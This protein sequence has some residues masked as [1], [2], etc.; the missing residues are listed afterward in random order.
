MRRNLKLNIQNLEPNAKILL[1]GDTHLGHPTLLKDHLQT[2][3]RDALENDYYVLLMGDLIE[4]GITGSVGDSLYNQDLRPQEQMDEIIELLL[5]L[6]AKGVILGSHQGNHEH[7]IYKATGINVAKIIAESLK[8][9]YLHFACWSALRTGKQTYTFYTLHG[10][11]AAKT[12][13][14][15]MK[16]VMDIAQSF[17]GADVVAMGHVHD[18]F[19]HFTEKQFVDLKNKKIVYKQQHIAVTGHYL[20]Y[21]HNYAQQQGMPMSRTGS[22]LVGLDSEKHKVN[23]Y[24]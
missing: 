20:G 21:E 10:R 5:P 15:K 8:I 24:V 19:T 2:N 13:H 11:G 7:R 14:S 12:P 22:P 3:I 9:P 6:A 17:P 1:L 23:I 18:M 4:C 16:A